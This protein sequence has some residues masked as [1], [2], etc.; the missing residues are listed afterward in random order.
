MTVRG[1]S[2]SPLP[3][4]SGPQFLGTVVPK[5][6]GPTLPKFWGPPFI[7][8]E[9]EVTAQKTTT[10]GE[11]SSSFLTPSHQTQDPQPPDRVE[12]LG[13]VAG[14]S[15]PASASTHVEAEAPPPVPGLPAELAV[16]QTLLIAIIARFAA[17]F[18]KPLDQARPT[19]IGLWGEFRAEAKARGFTFD[20]RWLGEALDETEKAKAGRKIK[21]SPWVYFRGILAKYARQGGPMRDGPTEHQARAT[22]AELAAR[23]W[24]IVLKPDGTV[25]RGKIGGDACAWEDLPE[26]LRRRFK[27]QEGPIRDWLKA[28]ETAS[29]SWN[30]RC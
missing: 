2:P 15:H 17:F 20:V 22:L 18:G 11:S 6:W 3:N 24:T 4:R 16:H 30:P 27:E 14:T 8:K 21:G 12:S 9:E 1:P 13:P 25:C 28:R 7:S 23:G 29:Q 10:T 5:F 19:L 26:S